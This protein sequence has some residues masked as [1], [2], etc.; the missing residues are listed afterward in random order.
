[1][2][3]AHAPNAF[4][5]QATYTNIKM[6]E[7]IIKQNFIQVN[8]LL[9]SVES[10]IA[11]SSAVSQSMFLP[12]IADILSKMERIVSSS[13]QMCP[14][15]ESGYDSCSSQDD[16]V[17]VPSMPMPSTE[18]A[19]TPS[20]T[21]QANSTFINQLTSFIE[22]AA[23][24]GVYSA[25]KAA[26]KRKRK[27]ARRARRIVPAEFVTLWQT[28]QEKDDVLQTMV[29]PPC[30]YPKVD[31][32]KVNERMLATLPK[33]KSFPV[34]SCSQD[35]VFYAPVRGDPSLWSAPFYSVNPFGTLPGHSTNHGVITAP[36]QHKAHGYINVDGGWVL[37]ATVRGQEDVKTKSS[38]P[39]SRMPRIRA[40]WRRRRGR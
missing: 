4:N 12:A 23:P 8:K 13:S 10:K 19:S 30:P 31:W 3:L 39:R 28:L 35:P 29:T 21:P 37:D 11:A 2:D 1:M 6:E 7:D 32:S 25:A 17:P 40:P 9:Q 24:S 34:S 33:P 26:K 22:R 38:C 15:S 5:A 14:Q 18:K 27:A 20:P 16:S 36:D